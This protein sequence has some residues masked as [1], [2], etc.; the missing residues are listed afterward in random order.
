MRT[1]II[2]LLA[3][4]VITAFAQVEEEKNVETGATEEKD[5][6]YD[7]L[8]MYSRKILKS[9]EKIKKEFIKMANAMLDDKNS[10]LRVYLSECNIDDA[11]IKMIK[12]RLRTRLGKAKSTDDRVKVIL[13]I[14]NKRI[15]RCEDYIVKNNKK[16]KKLK[17]NSKNPYTLMGKMVFKNLFDQYIEAHDATKSFLKRMRKIKKRVEKAI[18]SEK[19]DTLTQGFKYI[20]EFGEQVVSNKTTKMFNDYKEKNPEFA[21][22]LT[23]IQTKWSSI[24][25]RTIKI[26]GWML[27][28]N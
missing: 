27:G 3:L 15:S 6:V 10:T 24:K 16:Y 5:T 19:L 22:Q 1:F 13:K 28:G 25:D 2:V 17:K 20:A 21:D 26:F 9:P 18:T 11:G 4:F 7:E 14:M 12:E 8:E 23:R